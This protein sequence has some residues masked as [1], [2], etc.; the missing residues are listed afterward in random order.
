MAYTL[1]LPRDS[2]TDTYQ[3][4]SNIC[5]MHDYLLSSITLTNGRIATSNFIIMKAI[6]SVEYNIISVSYRTIVTD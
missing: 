3:L 6:S 5:H 2:Q 4:C 1:L